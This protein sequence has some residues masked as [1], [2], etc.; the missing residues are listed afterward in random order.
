MSSLAIAVTGGVACGKS[1]V[2]QALSKGLQLGGQQVFDADQFVRQLY[3][4][5]EILQQM[6]REF[7]GTV[8]AGHLD[9]RR[10][11]EVVFADPAARRR[12]EAILHPLVCQEWR[13]QLA[14]SRAS[15]TTFLAEIP[16]L[17]E[18]GA[19]EMFDCVVV[20]AAS[21]SVQRDRL[22]NGR[23]LSG[24]VALGILA[25]QMPL[26]EKIARAD[27]VVWNDGSL[28]VLQHQIKLLLPHLRRP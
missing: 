25:S 3:Q 9:R 6:E 26:E 12:L 23:G 24:E 8:H 4:R 20:V 7:P 15:E 27:F 21:R 22:Q 10:L 17:Y 1:T 19:A 2:R 28:D 16:L 14:A 18:V 13:R 11:R 5:G